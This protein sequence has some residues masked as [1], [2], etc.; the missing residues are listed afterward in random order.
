MKI[1]S[2]W[3][4]RMTLEIGISFGNLIIY[5]NEKLEAIHLYVHLYLNRKSLVCSHVTGK[6]TSQ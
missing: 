6:F 5:K 4:L 3:L 2:Q 1:N